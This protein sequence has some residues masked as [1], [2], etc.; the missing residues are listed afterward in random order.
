MTDVPHFAL[1]FRFASPQAAV[2]EQDSID[3]VADACLA[4]IVCPVGFRVELP[5]FGLED[6]TFSTPSPDLDAIRVAL[7]QWEPRAAATLAEYPDLYDVL[8]AHVEVDVTVR[9]EA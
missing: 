6:P 1:P 2:N 3:E 4:I 5:A 7:D 9:T 8:L